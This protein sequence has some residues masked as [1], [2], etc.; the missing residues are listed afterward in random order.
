M[1]DVDIWRNAGI[2]IAATYGELIRIFEP[3]HSMTDHEP[4]V[5]EK[6]CFHERFFLV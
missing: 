5:S 4:H 3:T 1:F 2:Q 6:T